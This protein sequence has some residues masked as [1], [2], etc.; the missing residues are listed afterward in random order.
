MGV[1]VPVFIDLEERAARIITR[2]TLSAVRS[3]TRGLGAAVRRGDMG[4]AQRLVSAI[5]LGPAANEV[6]SQLELI[7]LNAVIL[8]AAQFTEGHDARR[9]KFVRTREIPM[10]IGNQVG[11]IIQGLDGSQTEIVRI[12]AEKLL[13]EA[14]AEDPTVGGVG[15]DE[16][17]FKSDDQAI[18][19]HLLKQFGPG[20]L[21][22]ALTSA[23][24]SGVKLQAKVSANLMTSRMSAFGA[25][26]QAEAGGIPTYQW[27]AVL[28]NRTCPFCSGMHGKVFSVGQSLQELRTI[29]MSQDVNVARSLSPWPRQN[30]ASINSLAGMSQDK[31]QQEGFAKPPAHP[32]C[33]CVLSIVGT[34]PKKEITGFQIRRIKR[35]LKD[36]VPEPPTRLKAIKDAKSTEEMFKKPSG[37]WLEDR[38]TNVHDPAI[39]K[40]FERKAVVPLDQRPVYQMLGGGSGAGKGTIVR[41]GLVKVPKRMVILD[42]DELKK[43]LPEYVSR[44]SSGDAS[45]AAFAHQESSFLST[46]ALSRGFAR[47]HDMLLDG[48]GD[49]TIDK[50]LGRVQPAKDLGYLVKADYVTIPTQ[51]A[52]TRA[53]ARAQRTGRMVPEQ[54][55]RT[56]HRDVSRT[57]KVAIDRNVF[58]EVRLWDNAAGKEPILVMQQIRGQTTVFRSD[59]WDAFL[60]KAEENVGVSAVK[61]PQAMRKT[62]KTAQKKRQK[63]ARKGKI[64]QR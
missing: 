64:D 50:L 47:R 22:A 7:A 40:L 9:T 12:A 34:V 44:V 42:A 38:V 2:A 58:D 29:I 30:I 23:V 46:R 11:Q 17:L 18:L 15:V 31:L 24:D 32:H 41:K 21:S 43:A 51:E 25:L 39:E 45:A 60:A 28:D 10:E 62:I 20:G 54:V 13:N 55:I 6:R 3:Q 14:D 57:F 61:L 5:N 36:A 48:T 63:K 16:G 27:N 53:I 33:R 4:G 19:V 37:Q 56:I 49:G 8:G 1:E 26:S 35:R 59:L 52:I